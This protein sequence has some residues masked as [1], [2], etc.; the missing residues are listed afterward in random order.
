MTVYSTKLFEV[1]LDYPYDPANPNDMS[2]T[3]GNAVNVDFDTQPGAGSWWYVNNADNTLNST[4]DFGDGNGPQAISG[5][6][7]GGTVELQDGTVTTPIAST[8]TVAVFEVG[9]QYYATF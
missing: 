5:A 9:G 8:S 4:I 1:T 3:V 7:R 6:A 2:F